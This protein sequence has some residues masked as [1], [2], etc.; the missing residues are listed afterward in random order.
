VE[1]CAFNTSNTEHANTL[2]VVEC[3]LTR[4]EEAARGRAVLGATAEA[5]NSGWAMIQHRQPVCVCVCVCVCRKGSSKPAAP[6]PTVSEPPPLPRSESS[7][8]YVSRTS[9][10]RRLTCEA[11]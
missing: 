3:K 10:S 7:C 4:S 1:T 6:D 5:Q 8:W 2:L 9:T 11:Q